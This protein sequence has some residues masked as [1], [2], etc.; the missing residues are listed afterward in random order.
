MQVS[1]KNSKFRTQIFS[2]IQFDN[3]KNINSMNNKSFH[4]SMVCCPMAIFYPAI[5]FTLFTLGHRLQL[6]TN[7]RRLKDQRRTYYFPEKRGVTNK[8]LRANRVSFKSSCPV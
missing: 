8:D 2:C 3:K 5:V 1:Y 7:C 6:G 4:C